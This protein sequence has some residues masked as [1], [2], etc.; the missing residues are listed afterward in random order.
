MKI[1]ELWR[2]FQLGLLWQENLKWQGYG[3]E[4]SSRRRWQLLIWRRW[5]RHNGHCSHFSPSSLW[6]VTPLQQFGN[7]LKTKWLLHF[8]WASV[9]AS[10]SPQ[11]FGAWMTSPNPPSMLV[12]RVRVPKTPHSGYP[13]QHVLGPH[14]YRR[15]EHDLAS[16]KLWLE[17]GVQTVRNSPWPCLQFHCRGQPGSTPSEM[18]QD[19]CAAI[20]QCDV[21]TFISSCGQQFVGTPCVNFWC[22]HFQ[23]LWWL[24]G[25]NCSAGDPDCDSCS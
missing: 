12:H 6:T 1:W 11:R 19:A 24:C 15:R 3:L 23:L 21:S 8:L 16:T 5:P 10:S 2:S 20:W 9:L 4:N 22:L 18:L 7:R 14:G 13:V 25:T 17:A